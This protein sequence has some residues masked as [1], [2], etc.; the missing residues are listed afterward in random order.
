MNSVLNIAAFRAL[1][2][3]YAI[4]YLQGYTAINDGGEG[5]FQYISTDTSSLDNGGT[6]IVDAAGHR[7]HRAEAGDINV[8]WFGAMG[9]GVT[10]D[11]A[12]IQ[13]ADTYARTFGGRVF[14]PGGTYMVSQLVL[15]S[16][17][18]WRGVGREATIIQQIVGS[19][20]DLV[21]DNNSN[22]NWGSTSPTL[23]VDG[24][25]L[26]EVTLN[27]NWNA[28]SGNT[29]GSGIAC[30]CAR[31]ILRDVFITNCAQYGMRTEW[32]GSSAGGYDTFTMEGFLK[33][34]ASTPSA[35]TDG[36]I[37]VPG[38]QFRLASSL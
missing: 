29:S 20:T 12:T 33:T 16:G 35:C 23:I 19:N 38:T 24:F 27:G 9:D 37:T 31:P 21:Y 14:L 30:Y 10:N 25:E 5:F 11:T 22:A 36:G 15:Y 7:Y 18:N 3:A 28:G 6:I 26:Q 32:Y 1:T 34:S 13:A 17:S 2:T 4:I 8:K